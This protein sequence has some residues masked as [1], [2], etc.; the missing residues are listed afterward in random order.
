LVTIQLGSLTYLVLTGPLLPSTFLLQILLFTG[1]AIGI[2]AL[3]VMRKTTFKI[4]PDVAQNGNLVTNG[5]YK[6]IRHPMY[7]SLLIVA[8]ALVINHPTTWRL[9]TLLILS[10][11]LLAKV[12]YEE[13]LLMEH[14][15]QYND[16]TQTTKRL[17]PFIY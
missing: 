7:T 12:H 16:Y 8:L 2:A 6:Y 11:D 17:L 10:G 9:V 4:V 13:S 3:W 5:P 1:I 15:Q 14:F